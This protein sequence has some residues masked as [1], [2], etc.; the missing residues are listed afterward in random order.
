MY[1][2]DDMRDIKLGMYLRFFVNYLDIGQ[3]GMVGHKD[4][5]IRP[6]AKAKHDH[7]AFERHKKKAKQDLHPMF[8]EQS[9]S[10]RPTRATRGA[11]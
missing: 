3:Q 7:R 4:G 2:V 11:P 9:S 5:K 1:I 8:G 10:R 6:R